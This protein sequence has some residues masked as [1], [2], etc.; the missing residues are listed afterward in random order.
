[1]VATRVIPCLDVRGGRVVKGVRFSD[2]RD[3]G[4]PAD[5]SVQYQEQGA[6]EVTIL[7]VSATQE[8]RDHAVVTVRRVRADLSIPL[9]V[10][11]GVRTV[12]DA[13]TLLEAGADRLSVNSAAVADPALISVLAERFGA[14]CIVASVDA[15]RRNDGFEVL[16]R[17]GTFDTGLDATLWSRE[18]QERGAGE[19]LLTSW[20]A[21]GT[22]SGYDLQLV[23]SVSSAVDVPVVA[24][25]GAGEPAHLIDAVDAGADAVLVASIVHDGIY[26]VAELKGSMA[27]AGIEVR[28]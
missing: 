17:S 13:E 7:D 25:G 28:R 22:T 23:T 27:D 3:V 19:I 6:D 12:G 1:M 15:A 9:T 8:E 14:Q 18:C 10:G 20:D 5:A 21:D 4:D 11:G 24:S 2:L 16:T 26:T